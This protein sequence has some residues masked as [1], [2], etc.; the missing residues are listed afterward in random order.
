MSGLAAFRSGSSD[1]LRDL[2]EQHFQHDLNDDDREI[3]RRAGSK[4]ST[5]AK[6]GSLLGIGLGVLAAFR[7]RK[8]RLTYF[9]AFRAMEKPVEVRFADGRTEP[10]PDITAHLTPSKWGDAA[11]YFFFSVGGLFIGGEAGLLSG[12]ASA[13]RTITKNPE[14]RERIEKAWNNY[15]IDAMKQ[16]IRKLEGKEGKSKLAQLFSS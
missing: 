10:I 7:L 11:T 16:E 5:H 2:A 6:I 8:M 15:R 9:N 13:S 4:V 12:T 14:A 1:E 3:L